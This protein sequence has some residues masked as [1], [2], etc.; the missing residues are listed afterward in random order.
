MGGLT[1]SWFSNPALFKQTRLTGTG[2]TFTLPYAP[3]TNSLAL[4]YNGMFLTV[5]IDYTVT[6]SGVI[7]L[8][9]Y[10]VSSNDVLT[11]HYLH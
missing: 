11:A 7:T 2:T 5:N 9:S 1:A 6:V 8:T 10:V 4:Y 3:L